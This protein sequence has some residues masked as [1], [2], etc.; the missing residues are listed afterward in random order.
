[1][2]YSAGTAFLQVVPSFRNVEKAMRKQAAEIGRE[3]D[4]SVSRALPRG[5]AEGA[6]NAKREGR[7][8]GDDYSGELSRAI[9]KHVKQSYERLPEMEITA[10]SSDAD[11]AIARVRN[12]LREIHDQHVDLQIDDAT[13]LRALRR[14]DAQLEQIN[15]SAATV[16]VHANTAAARRDLRQLEDQANGFNGR[17]TE[18][19]VDDQFSRELIRAAR[20]AE[21]DLPEISL[22]FDENGLATEVAEIRAILKSIGD[23]ETIGIDI[24]DDEMIRK[25]REAEARLLV[26]HQLG[27]Q[28]IRLEADTG[29][30]LAKIEAF[31]KTVQAR[32]LAAEREAQ[33]EADQIGR[34]HV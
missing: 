23:D 29:A 25:L 26:L 12:E 31:F 7:R 13:A 3:M 28:D 16:S 19:H 18:R 15:R 33:A 20:A 22:R 30:A 9:R 5:M 10:D 11:K 24:D 27:E 6:R 14:V 32:R 4:R 8:A 1:M 34:A 2:P 17:R 21:R